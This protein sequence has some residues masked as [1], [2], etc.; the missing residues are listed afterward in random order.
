[1]KL[2]IA[3]KNSIAAD[4]LRY[5]LDLK[6]V[7]VF[8][9]LNKTE[10]FI[11][12][13]QKS[14]GFYAKLWNVQIITL[15]EAQSLKES[16]F[17]SLEFDRIIKTEL[18]KSKELFNIHFSKLPA[19]KGMYTSA[20]P[21]LNGE[22]QSGV[23]LHKIDNGIDTGDIIDQSTFELLVTYTA[24]SL[25]EKYISQGTELVIKNLKNI[26]NK[27]YSSIP[28]GYKNSTYYSKQ[29]L[30]YSNINIDYFKTAF[31]IEQQ[32]R[33]FSFREYQL[34]KYNNYSIG[35]WEVL[36][37]KSKLKPGSLI[38]E[39]EET[40][41]LSTIDFDILLYKDR[42]EEL[43]N[44]C[45]QNNLVKLKLLLSGTNLDLETKTVEGWNALIIA[46]YNGAYDCVN[47]LLIEGVDVNA[48]NY[49]N[50][51][52]IMYAKSNAIKT[53]ELNILELLLQHGADVNEKDVFNKTVFDWVKEEDLELYNFFKNR[54]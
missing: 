26:I 20:L 15:S 28:Q 17:L 54:L 40:I 3:G 11:N 12:S 49:N 32:L 51:S 38:N 7:E 42:Y 39:N 19:Y 50:T 16:I 4:V 35:D 48:K 5:V 46:T 53:R 52:V 18:F 43:W 41:L 21:I 13:F 6:T 14:L 37:T 22:T 31:Q 36:D 25:Y 33:A 30:N 1:M 2:I 45:R 29:A 8:V 34:P 9:V 23:T 10:N 27:A 24:R 47:Y 44:Y